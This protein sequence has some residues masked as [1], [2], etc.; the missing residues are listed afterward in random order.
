MF[1][2]L[3]AETED[4]TRQ[5]LHAS[6]IVH[7]ELGPGLLQSVYEVCLAHELRKRR[8]RV[9]T[10]VPFPV[11]YRGARLD[12]G[13]RITLLVDKRIIIE[14]ESVETLSP[15]PDTRL[16][17]YLKLTRLHLGFLINFNVPKIRDGI[18]RHTL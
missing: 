1:T 9:D 13:L 17:T 7:A 16:L 15:A 3:S 11:V 4:I 14:L 8:I 12:A 2:S 6:S 10:H 5:V 18:R